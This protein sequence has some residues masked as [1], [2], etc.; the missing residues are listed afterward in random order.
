[1]YTLNITK[2]IKKML[3]NEV[4]DFTFKIYYKRIGFLRK[5]VIIQK[6]L[7]RSIVPWEQINRKNT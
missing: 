3:V 6:E 1:M 5:A 2:A 4:K 7:T